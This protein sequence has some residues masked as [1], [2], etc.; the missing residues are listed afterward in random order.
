MAIIL[1][2]TN[3]KYSDSEKTL[4]NLRDSIPISVVSILGIRL[5][6]SWK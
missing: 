4:L 1:I 2:K 6:N 5:G 3:K